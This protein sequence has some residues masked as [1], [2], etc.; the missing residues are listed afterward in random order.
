M[1]TSLRFSPRSIRPAAL[2]ASAFTCCIFLGSVRA[3]EAPT[4]E[5]ERQLQAHV[6]YLADDL[7]E[8]RGAGT[9]GHG[10]AM[11]YVAAQFTRLGIEP[12]GDNG[13]FQQAL[14]M[15]E[16]RLDLSSGRLVIRHEGAETSLT[17][18]NDMIARPA[19]GE[20]GSE[21]TAP[22]VFVGFGIHAPEFGYDDFSEAIDV[23]GKIAVVLAGSPDKLPSTAKAHYS[24]EKTAE[25]ARRGAVGIVTI[26]TPAEEK[27]RPWAFVVNSARFP[28][29]RL[30]KADGSLLEAYPELRATASVS[31]AASGALFTHT[32]R[33]IAE[34]FAA[35]ERSETQSFPL[36]IELTLSASA[37]VSDV[38]SANV[39]G[40]IPGSDPQL[41]GEPIVVTAHLDHLGIGPAVTG[42]SIYNGA[43]DNALGTAIILATAEQLAAGPRL[44]RPVL[45]AALTGEE[46]GLLG[47]FHLAQH[48]PSRISRYAANF[49]VDMPVILGPTRDVI[50]IGTEHSTLGDALVSVARDVA[51]TVS[52]DPQPEEV[53]FV[54][55][56]Q[57]PFVRA[58]VPA[59]YLKSGRKSLDPAVDLAALEADFRKNHYHKPSDDLSR[60]I[61]WKSAAAF[62]ELHVAL[63]RAVGN[64]PIAPTW[65]P[66]DF[67]GKMFGSG[68]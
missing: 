68:R 65:K 59:L 58:G 47:A 61:D 35:S 14:T 67:F 53:V 8:G 41:A 63:L 1:T 28:A 13:S 26:D 6:A 33:P 5:T 45:F 60:P 49:N 44:R 15:R 43:L 18:I 42:D 4:A 29:M 11:L 57:Y 52:P 19:S 12:A 48:P 51:F 64:E 2:L 34:V 46:K 17:A 56:D 20:S 22:A 25:L 27:R 9:R 21:I 37:E 30:I 23:R 31:R 10:L 24:R 66:G 32:S 62:T 54:R 7:L 16:S 40:W 3:A 38:S 55:S 39:L 36:N 50:G